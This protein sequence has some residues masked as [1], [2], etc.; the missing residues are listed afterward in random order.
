MVYTSKLR[1]KGDR[2]MGRPKRREYSVTLPFNKYKYD[3]NLIPTLTPAMKLLGFLFENK[4][5]GGRVGK[6]VYY[7]EDDDVCSEKVITKKNKNIVFDALFSKEFL[8]SEYEKIKKGATKVSVGIPFNDKPQ[9]NEGTILWLDNRVGK[10]NK[11]FL[12]AFYNL[13][14]I[15]VNR[16]IRSICVENLNNTPKAT[17]VYK[18]WKEGLFRKSFKEDEE[19]YAF[20]NKISKEKKIKLD[21]CLTMFNLAK[22]Y[23]LDKRMSLENSDIIM[24]YFRF[25]HRIMY[26]LST[27]TLK[28]IDEEDT[29]NVE[30]KLNFF[31]PNYKKLLDEKDEYFEKEVK[32]CN[33]W[34]KKLN[35]TKSQNKGFGIYAN[36]TNIYGVLPMC[37]VPLSNENSYEYILMKLLALVLSVYQSDLIEEHMSLGKYYIS[38]CHHCGGLFFREDP[39][40]RFCNYY[41]DKTPCN[42]KGLY[43][44]TR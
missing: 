14:P 41:D 37:F 20:Y 36:K 27:S 29:E 7:I 3:K 18:L 44:R 32:E 2:I 15:M 24:D 12:E 6:P 31:E 1:N 17:K 13:L 34:L 23:N 43:K 40:K 38:V 35:N 21:H 19:I 42:N 9:E 33:D 28:L 16:D 25:I 4:V 39:Q 26:V 11:I 5:I 10:S 30:I 8:Y 22:K